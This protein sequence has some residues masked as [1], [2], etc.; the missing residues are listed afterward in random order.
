MSLERAT[1]TLLIPGIKARNTETIAIE[2]AKIIK[3]ENS[4]NLL[5]SMATSRGVFEFIMTF[6]L[7]IESVNQLIPKYNHILADNKIFSTEISSK[8]GI[9][10][11]IPGVEMIDAE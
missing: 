9:L 3:N 11:L 6:G 7:I 1:Y 2:E 4:E 10:K 8:I 5:T